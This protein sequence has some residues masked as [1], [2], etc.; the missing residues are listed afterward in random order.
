MPPTT[1]GSR[2]LLRVAS[3]TALSVQQAHTKVYDIQV[4]QTT[5]AP[6]NNA[7]FVGTTGILLRN[8]IA[9]SNNN[10]D[11]GRAY[12]SQG[13]S[14]PNSRLQNCV[15]IMINGNG[16]S[17][18]VFAHDNASTQYDN[19]LAFAGGQ[20]HGFRPSSND[21]IVVRN[22]LAVSSTGQGFSGS[23]FNGTFSTNNAT[24]TAF[25]PGV[26][27]RTNQTFTFVDSASLNFHL[28]NNDTGAKGFGVNLRN[29]NTG[30][31]G[32]D[33]DGQIRPSTLWDIG[34]DQISIGF[35]YVIMDNI[36]PNDLR[37]QFTVSQNINRG[38]QMVIR[39]F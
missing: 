25:A 23:G 34:P 7:V 9:R 10:A 17:E 30:S 28:S 8:V 24:N 11:V 33:F 22:C 31:F 32:D 16:R 14:T 13:A 4:E 36:I 39:E 3:G 38:K 2:Y 26:N 37:G 18:G 29:S 12:F 27:T 15:G 35:R 1:D 19:C 21:N 5:N 20:R 6:N